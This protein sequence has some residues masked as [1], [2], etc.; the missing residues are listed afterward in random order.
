MKNNWPIKKLGEI[1]ELHYGKGIDK[2]LRSEDGKVPIYGANGI[3]GKTDKGLVSG[4]AIIVGRKG[5]AGQITRISGEFWPS[6]VTYYVFGNEK[7]DID[8]LFYLLKNLNLPQYA[9]GVKPGINR[10]KVYDIEI[11]IPPI[12]E[13]M[14]IVAKLEKLL[15]KVKEAKKLRKESQ[16]LAKNLLTAE[17]HRT[18]ALGKRKEKIKNLAELVNGRGFKTSEWTTATLGALPIIRIQNLNNPKK[19]FNYYKGNFDEK[20]LVKNNDLLFSWSGSRGTSFGPH[21][22]SGSKGILNQHIFKINH[23]ESMIQRK[24]FYFAMKYLVTEIEQSLHGGVGLVHITKT[25]FENFSINLPSILEQKKIVERLDAISERVKKL[26][27]YQKQT[28]EDLDSLEKSILH[29]AFSGNL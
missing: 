18:F 3:L 9:V 16:E 4:D 29:Q 12:E 21:I 17:L 25:K 1:I 15:G 24:Y 23:D 28:E 6:D 5:S 13:Q 7:M 19:G 8:Y 27:E 2:S 22:W 26:Q 10:N 11:S 20:I 14:R